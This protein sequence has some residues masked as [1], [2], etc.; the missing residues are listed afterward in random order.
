MLTHERLTE[1]LAYD[2]ETGIFTWKISVGATKRGRV[3][4]GKTQHGYRT[5]SLDGTLY[6]AHRLAWFYVHK[7]MPHE[8]DHIDRDRSNNRIDNL[9]SVNRSLNNHNRADVIGGTGYRGVWF[10]G[11]KFISIIRVNGR[12]RS[13]GTFN[14]AVDASEAYER[15][16]IKCGLP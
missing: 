8:I 12:R 2:A 1:A 9:R 10:S 6:Y 13:L 16:R 4:G 11:C 15:E 14:S 7:E 3:A 5:L